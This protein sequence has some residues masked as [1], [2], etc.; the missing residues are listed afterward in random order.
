MYDCI[1]FVVSLNAANRF[2]IPNL[3][4]SFPDI[5]YTLTLSEISYGELNS[6]STINVPHALSSPFHLRALLSAVQPLQPHGDRQW[7]LSSLFYFLY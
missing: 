6:L 2:T 5:S 1:S 7:L 3:L 4:P